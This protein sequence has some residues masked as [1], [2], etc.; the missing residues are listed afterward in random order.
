MKIQNVLREDKELKLTPQ[1]N[2][3]SIEIVESINSNRVP[4][5]KRYK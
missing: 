4:I 5:H 2:K 3:R 1:I